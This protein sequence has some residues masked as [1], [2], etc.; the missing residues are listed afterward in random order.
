MMDKL[1]LVFARRGDA[2]E[3]TDEFPLLLITRRANDF[4]TPRGG[5]I[6]SWRE[7]APTIRPASTP[8]IWTASVSVAASLS[9]SGHS[10]AIFR[11]R[12]R[13]MPGCGGAP[14]P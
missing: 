14:F 1:E 3:P 12:W 11:P 9:R 13:R 6:P 8:R 7:S 4:L 5:T 10:T 2:P